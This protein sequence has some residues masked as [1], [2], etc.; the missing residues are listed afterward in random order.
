MG[1][2]VRKWEYVKD[3]G[4]GFAPGACCP[5]MICERVLA[6]SIGRAGGGAAHFVILSGEKRRML[7]EIGELRRRISAK[8]HTSYPSPSGKGD[9]VSGARVL[10]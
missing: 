9:R 8:R 2:V 6:G 4:E 7:S 3:S 1:K 5:L 10:S